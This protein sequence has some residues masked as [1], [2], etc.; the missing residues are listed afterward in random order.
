MDGRSSKEKRKVAERV[1]RDQECSAPQLAI[2][3]LMDDKGAGLED[4]SK[5]LSQG[6]NG[7]Q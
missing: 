4:K 7:K 2:E 6:S 3:M 1:E 5:T